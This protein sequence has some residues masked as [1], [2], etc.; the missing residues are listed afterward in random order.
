VRAPAI[1]AER[2]LAVARLDLELGSYAAAEAELEQVLNRTPSSADALRT[3]VDLHQ[4]TA[5]HSGL[6]AALV[7]L[8]SQQTDLEAAVGALKQAAQVTLATQDDTEAAEKL[9]SEALQRVDAAPAVTPAQ[10]ELVRRALGQV[11][12]PLFELARQKGRTEEAQALA[13]RAI[14]EAELIGNRAAELQVHLGQEALATGKTDE[15]IG[16]FDA[17]LT[18]SPGLLEPTLALLEL[19]GPSGNHARIDQLIEA[20]LSTVA[21]GESILPEVERARLRRR[22]AAARQELGLGDGTLAALKEAEQ[23]SPGTLAEKLWLGETAFAQ[24]DFATALLHLAPLSSLTADRDALPE[25]LTPARLADVLDQAGQAAQALGKLDEARTLW[26]A[27]LTVA[28]D[29]AAA[30]NHYLDLLLAAGQSADAEEAL[31]MLSGRASQAAAAG[32]VQAARRDYRRAAALAAGPIADSLRAQEFLKQALALLPPLGEDSDG[33]LRDEWSTLLAQVYENAEQLGELSD[34]RGYAERLAQLAETVKG[35]SVW[36]SRAAQC[37]LRCGDG[38]G[39]KALLLQALLGTPAQLVLIG[40]Y[41]EQA[42]DEEAH[43]KLP[44]LL[45]AAMATA[46]SATTPRGPEWQAQLQGLWVRAATIHGR[47]GD[48]PLA[49]QAYERAL[50]VLADQTGSEAL[51]LRRAVL[52]VLPDTEH[53]RARG[54]LHALLA[55][56]PR[57]VVLLGKLQAVEERAQNKGAASRLSQLLHLLDPSQPV[58]PAPT[59]PP[60]DAKLDET[61]HARLADPEARAMADILA[62]L[63]DGVYS[64]K[65]PTLDSLGV[66]GTDRLQ[67]SETSPDELARAFALSSRVL[68]NQ[69]AGLYRPAGHTL[70][71]P[72]IMAKL[73]TAVIAS[74]QLGKRPIGELLFLVARAVEGLRPEFIMPMAMPV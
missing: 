50:T 70:L 30:T 34:A 3:L 13:Q 44:G 62:A 72:R 63:F 2:F 49:A 14:R 36:L 73:P 6:V 32:D 64:L 51:G 57:D 31:A 4:R 24:G 20:T 11:L 5:N 22:Q 37:A 1:L 26:Q 17:A 47:M 15:A 67:G 59:L 45:Q 40:D 18:A 12:V 42:T 74:P 56:S 16:F 55:A 9:L 39:A 38:T 69:R 43:E 35:Q 27:V 61:D 10:K 71:L 58:P 65:A 25:P 28:G 54:H 46:T 7:R 23:L 53:D 60:K 19:L 21:A 29:H 41:L 52:E 68:G 8:S 66:Q 48:G 33:A